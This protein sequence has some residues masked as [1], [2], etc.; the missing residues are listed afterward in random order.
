MKSALLVVA[1]I[2]VLG[3]ACEKPA[4]DELD[5]VRIAARKHLGGAAIFI[6]D[7][8]GF[9]ADEGIRLEFAEA[10]MRSLQA[11]PLL[12]QGKLDVLSGSVSAGLFSA[13]GEGAKLRMVGDRGHVGGTC[14]FNGV[15]GSSRSFSSNEPSGSEVAGKVFS[16]NYAVTAEFV[17]EKFLESRGLSQPSVRSASLSET[18]EPQAL[19]SGAIDA[20]HATE[21][22]ISRLKKEGHRVLGSAREYAAG[23]QFGV[24]VFGPTLTV[25]NRALGQ[26]FM[27]A[28]VRGVRQHALG[29]TPRNVEIIASRMGFDQ[30]F[31]RSA[32]FAN[33]RPDAGLDTA[34][35]MEFQRWS[36]KKGYGRSVIPAERAIDLTFSRKAGAHADS[37]ESHG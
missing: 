4:A 12:E 11:I 34:W 7:E 30:E 21:P 2:A 33:M 15:V 31:L 9:F 28:Y 24:I 19:G 14:D 16:I 23:A 27:N 17:I 25:E 37:L 6:A 36:V 8:E 29:A 5:L 18:M 26:R 10:P 22:Y 1:A 20:T 35:M 32:C 13:A 3:S